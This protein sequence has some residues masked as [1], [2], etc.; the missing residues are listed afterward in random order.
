[1]NK[2]YKVIWSKVR[3]CYIVVSEI[4]KSYT[5]GKSVI[6]SP[7]KGLK[8]I[9]AVGVLLSVL[10]MG[11]ITSASAAS[12]GVGG[13][14]ANGYDSVSIGE[15][16]IAGGY[17]TI[18]VVNGKAVNGGDIYYD[19]NTSASGL[20]NGTY[21]VDVAGKIIKDQ[22]DDTNKVLVGN[23]TV[24][25]ANSFA[26]ESGA[27]AS[28]Y[29]ASATGKSST[30]LGE[31]SKAV[32]DYS[33]ALGAES[34]SKVYNSIAIGHNAQTGPSDD[35]TNLTSVTDAIAI[36]NA[37][38]S[39]ANK[40]VALGS[41]ASS[42][43]ANGMA[44]GTK[45][46]VTGASSMAIGQGASSKGTYGNALGYQAVSE[47]N[48]SNAI[49]VQA[50]AVGGD[51]TAI[52]HSASTSVTGALA[53]GNS[54]Q[55][56]GSNGFAIGNSAKSGNTYAAALGYK[57]EAGGN[58][59]VAFGNVASAV[60][61]QSSAIGYKASASGG[62]SIAFG[63][64]S[65]ASANYSVALGYGSLVSGIKS[66]AVGYSNK[67]HGAS[68]GALGDPNVI[69]GS[70]SY[71][72]GNDNTIGED[73]QDSKGK[74]TFVLG[75]NVNTV[76]NGSVA[77]G[78]GTTLIEDN[79][80]SVGS[81]SNRRRIVNL[82]DGTAATNAATVGQTIELEAGDNVI[83]TED[84]I[85]SIG[86]KKY[87]ISASFDGITYD[88]SSKG[89][90]TFGGTNGTKLTNIAEGAVNE[91]SKDAVTG[92]QL[93]SEESARE[94][95]DIA[96][97]ENIDNEVS[98]RELAINEL[99]EDL[100]NKVGNLTAKD[101]EIEGKV[102]AEITARTEA[103]TALGARI[104]GVK[105]DVDNV[106]ANAVMYDIGSDKG[107]VSLVG[108]EGTVIANVKA[109]EVSADSKEAVNGSQLYTE[110]QL[111]VNADTTLQGNIDAEKTA[112]EGAITD[113]TNT[114]NT[115]V[116]ALSAKDTE[117][118]G[119]ITDLTGDINTKY[120]TLAAKDIEIEGKVTA[121]ITARIEADTALGVRIDG[122]KSDVDNVK[123][124][125]VMYDIG[126]DKGKVSLA[127][128]EGTVIAN[129]KAGEVSADSKEAVNGSQLYTEQ[130]ARI[131]ADITLQG[132]IDAEKTARE[133][134]ITDLTNTLNTKVGALTAKDT[135]IEDKIT[136]LIGDVNTKYSTLAAKDTE[137]EGK[138]TAEIT[139]R[140][141]ADTALGTRIDGIKSDVDNVKANAI[142]YDTG[143]DKGKL[144]LAGAEGTVIANVK[145]GEV[146]AD[147]KEAVNGSQL[148]TEQQARINADTTLQGNIDAEKTAR[149]GA[150]TDLNN[151]LNTKVG[152]LTAKD[153]EIEGKI[154]DLTG[155]VNTKYST[156]AAKDT[157]IEGKVTAEITARTEADTALGTRIDGVKSNLEGKI[158]AETTNR[159]SE[160]SR[161]DTRIDNINTSLGNIGNA[162]FYD[163]NDKKK[164]SLVGAEGTVIAN[165]KAGE[166]SADSKEAVNGSQL[167]TE[168]QVRANA[169]TTL[170]GN[171]DAEKIA[172]E[173]AITNLTN[174]LNIKVGALTAKDTEI[175]GKVTAETTARIE[176]DTVLGTRI[177]GV[178]S[179]L[180]GKITAEI[181]NRESEVS[182]LD[183]R[184]DNINT[185]FNASLANAV[186]YDAGSDK[187]KVSLVGAEGTVIANVKAG[188]VSADSKEAVNGSQLYTEQ[189]ARINAD[190][191]LQGNIDAEKTAREGA[192]TDLTNTFN[193]KVGALSAKDTEIE[194][195]I[196]DLTG[197]VNTKY[198]TLAAKDTEI[199]G[200]VTAETTARTEA[201]TALGIRIDGVKSD[202]D[203]VKANAVMYDADSDKGK[204]SLAGAE[205]TVIANVKAGEVSADSKE[206][207]NG[208]QLYTEQQARV[209]ADTTLQGN[210]DA[211]KTAREGAIT[212]LTNTLNTKVGT[213]I[214]KDT[215]I[216][217][218]ITAETTN[219]ES[220]VSRL[221]TRIDNINTN[222]NASLAN[223]V[224]Y[225]AGS[226]KGKVSLAGAEGTVIANVKA[227]EVSADSKEAVNGSQL[228][229]EQQA[230]INAD[231]TLQGNIDAEKTA[232]E[233]AITDLTNTLN[234][235]VGTLIAKDTEIEG[236]IIDLTSDVN[237]KYST[238]AAK[239][240]EIEG[241]VTAE[242]TARTEADTALGTR[243]DG[244]KSDVDNVKA[245]A[246]TYDAGSDK[247]KVSLAGAEGTV[248]ANVK[249]GEVSADS[250]EA[251]NGSQ[252]YTE[253]QARINADTTLQ[254]N[255]D[256]EKIAREGADNLIIGRLDGLENSIGNL[257][258]SVVRYSDSDKS[259]ILLGGNTGTVIGNLKAGEVSASSAEAVNG[260]QLYNEQETRRT[261]DEVLQNNISAEEI[262][263]KN[264][265]SELE[266]AINNEVSNRQD[267]VNNLRFELTGVLN[268]V[269]ENVVS[270]AD[271]AKNKVSFA[272]TNGTLLT[273]LKN[274]N[275]ASGSTDAV[276]GDQLYKEEQARKDAVSDIN[277]RLDNI[278]AS[279]GNGNSVKYDDADKSSVTLG[280]ENGT[281]I[282]NVGSGSI[283]EGS[284]DA[285]N[286]GQLYNER[287]ERIDADNAL[288]QEFTDYVVGVTEGTISYDNT[289][290]TS[291]TFKGEN[292]TS[293][294]NISDGTIS[295]GSK[296]A[297]NGGQLFE[298]N[299]KLEALG[300]KV[301]T[302]KD[303]GFVKENKTVGE[304]INVLDQ[305]VSDNAD[306]IGEL[307]GKVSSG[308]NMLGHKVNNAGAHAAALA[309]LNPVADDDSKFSFAAGV[310][311][312][313]NA[314]AGAIGMFYRPSDRY[315]LSIGGTTGNGEHMYNMGL[316]I[317]LD[318]NVGG[319]FASKK[320]MICEIVNLRDERDAQNE[321]M[322]DLIEENKM[323]SDALMYQNK[324]I[325]EL[326]QGR[327]EQ[328]EKIEKL[329]K[330]V[331]KLF[332]G[333]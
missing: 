59:S 147:S 266:N 300:S 302:V 228:Y 206:A 187:G 207:V 241:K 314:R 325:A 323:Q 287:Q 20:A 143:S 106:K 188:E 250:K 65:A 175:E 329:M 80:V 239:D 10:G 232:R 211:E 5:R 163:D 282:K 251:V 150:I 214:A 263:R 27:L 178:K 93:Y 296:D 122:V 75:S 78:F 19:D 21:F 6:V 36:G 306:A 310:G 319:P 257:D 164:I 216:E 191:T 165:V 299:T 62:N 162:V 47:G 91:L 34:I 115:K 116:G 151:T 11:Y 28:G 155:D 73:G 74:N 39:S 280:G 31:D 183:T 105:S 219:R 212:D 138:V 264:K 327:I 303:G 169:D 261:S 217:G 274:G 82:A 8:N 255:I 86:Q 67:V 240:T 72:I 2:I 37:S 96:L 276:T 137:I 46:S 253:Q 139:A 231:T 51:S 229:T 17:K 245:N 89:V 114:F 12:Y 97:K 134:A 79:V 159:E 324:Q 238:L 41:E 168:Q 322:R 133:G 111:R 271:A 119:K 268:G 203:N 141:E 305:A 99:T 154:T 153:T 1:M 243:I 33:V 70:G 277:A 77:L 185:N 317:G 262:A 316:A 179:N 313:H 123:A 54:A 284:M 180:E 225:D 173:G 202:V 194:G 156:L 200:K 167:Y 301:G 201:D 295:E 129:V 293:L 121:E 95:A 160:V 117:I 102:T 98:A 304:N 52:G 288:R 92:S 265:D 16:S 15:G 24:L 258:D 246:V 291:I 108:A 7:S 71:A 330:L 182:R 331:E 131:N 50:S 248:I 252:L 42:I 174:T 285:V 48:W 286:G 260:S 38:L 68:S 326:Q 127:G 256:A 273:N 53:L 130:Q 14:T 120:S 236:K 186:M 125:A 66:V 281:M 132:N 107:K 237:I 64:S 87:K 223:A 146:S 161:L 142:M 289:D 181:T 101:T 126:S 279:S 4:A 157:E 226:D 100:N 307:S 56:N 297:I 45:A 118:E 290:K 18:K 83:V 234:T 328:E 177:D 320:A 55:G 269:L 224:M 170:Q 49:G 190:T 312:Y 230:R 124:N 254:G 88:D 275:V 94:D 196:T 148:Y 204:V 308:L 35:I 90:I 43:A 220:E 110:Q 22:D 63:S 81:E 85:N 332:E 184:I 198:S 84:G 76:A 113:L 189:Q 199:E 145:A 109:G 25:G 267:A 321:R 44:I 29:S 32:G 9:L 242:T 23:A 215:E 40:S 140:I 272:G 172:R 247:G 235:K 58:S 69:Y 315:Q 197:D 283:T 213:L 227:G 249:A 57:A 136:D 112:R 3:N 192:I 244:V 128:A 152:A 149:E 209:N 61:V 218:K 309:A 195:K 166:V 26:L 278:E 171:I 210:I 333:K 222:F 294:K 311:S 208:S 104:D 270:Y 318:K 135:E 30:A 144:S 158:T 13:G 298:T 176:A 103:D 60:G 221:D 259:T 193:T 233:G 292:G 205:G